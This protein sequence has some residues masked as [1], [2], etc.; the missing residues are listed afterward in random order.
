MT[1]RRLIFYYWQLTI[2]TQV[3]EI[4]G[5]ESR[6][7]IRYKEKMEQRARQEEELFTR[8][9]LTRTE[10]KKEK[11]LRKSRNG[12]VPYNF[13]SA[14]SW[15]T[16]LAIFCFL[17]DHLFLTFGCVYTSGCLVWQTVFM[18][19]LKLYPWRKILVRKCQASITVEGENLRRERYIELKLW[20]IE[21]CLIIFLFEVLLTKV[22]SL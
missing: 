14:W 19:R 4:V 6:E 16:K 12:Y 2:K 11:H 9:P 5:T 1:L 18:M 22:F 8:A 15:S 3:R 17:V 21:V 10:K 13:E 7:L 20:R